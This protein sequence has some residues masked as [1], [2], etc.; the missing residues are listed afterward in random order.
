MYLWCDYKRKI[1]IFL[2]LHWDFR[3]LFRVFEN[4]ISSQNKPF[5]LL[6]KK[7]STKNHIKVYLDSENFMMASSFLHEDDISK[8]WFY[9]N[10][11]IFNVLVDEIKQKDEITGFDGIHED[12]NIIVFVRLLFT[13]ATCQRTA[14]SASQTAVHLRNSIPL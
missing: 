9:M 6:N 8:T 11:W 2:L 14:Y 1:L 12:L 7:F 13:S 4:L 10:F 5:L 3:A